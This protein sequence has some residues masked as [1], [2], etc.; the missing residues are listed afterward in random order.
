MNC[1]GCGAQCPAGQVCSGG[2]CQIEC[3]PQYTSCMSSAASPDG[4]VRDAGGAGDAAATGP[5]VRCADLRTDDQHCGAC[6]NACPLGFS[7]VSRT[8]ELRC[9][10][11]QTNCDG[12]CVS[13][14]TSVTDCGACGTAC[15][16]QQRCVAGVC[17]GHGLPRGDD[18]LQGPP[19]PT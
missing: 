9:P 10:S 18:G 7:C 3:G 17:T 11:T 12:R 15:T 6:G 1:G 19:A 14:M 5:S 13:L 8:C 16:G 4:G 2:A